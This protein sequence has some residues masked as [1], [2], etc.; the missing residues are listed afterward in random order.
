MFTGFPDATIT[1]FL[2]LRLNNYTSYYNDTKDAFIRDVRAPFYSLINELAPLMTQIDPQME[3]RPN[4]CLARIHRDTRFTKDK[5]PYRDH[6]WF[7]FRRGGE[8]RDLSVMYWFE[9]SPESLEWGL[10]FWGENKPALDALRRVMVTDPDHMTG[11]IE[12]IGFRER[13]F[14]LSGTDSRRVTIPADLPVAL[15]AWYIKKQLYIH[16]KGLSVTDAFKP[17]L[18]PRVGDDFYAL[19]PLYTLLRT[20]ADTA[21]YTNENNP[22]AL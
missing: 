20:C 11:L 5:A 10:G 9:L 8:P 17:D 1:Y 14:M 13:D 4:K 22:E 6:L 21:L 18:S 2:G 15:H 3:I 19:S 16:K 12:S 7:L